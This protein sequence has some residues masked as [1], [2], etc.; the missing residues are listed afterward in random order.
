MTVER[1]APGPP[2][3]SV[4]RGPGR[5]PVPVDRII[6]AALLILDEEGAE[7]L[8]M[9]AV[10]AR[11][12][13]STA[14]IYRHFPTRSDLIVHVID[15]VL[16]EA[17]LDARNYR[18]L[19]W[20]QGSEKITGEIFAAFRRHRSSAL[21]LAD[22]TPIGPNAA[23]VRERML[24]VLLDGGFEAQVA[25]RCGAMLGHLVLGFAIQ[26]GG[27]RETSQADREAFRK[28]IRAMD[29]TQFPATDAVRRARW[30]PTGI[31]EEFSFA[32]QMTLDG[33]AHLPRSR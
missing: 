4:R 18:H 12:K 28:A 15:R 5:P 19:G 9:R 29:M 10:A 33:I 25:A 32:L 30:R 24:A 13:S 14:T 20:R 6:E 3:L 22:H 1:E 7:A 27:E 21:L 16:G 2:S 11:L 23:A 8:T 26:L 31:D 17:D